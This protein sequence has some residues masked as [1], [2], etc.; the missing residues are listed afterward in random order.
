MAFGKPAVAAAVGGPTDLIEHEGNGLLVPPGDLQQ[1]TAALARLLE[2]EALRAKLGGRASELVK[3]K[4]TFE[5]FAS[6][7]EHILEE[8]W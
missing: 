3:T 8:C 6:E 1:L 7:I 2:D 5:T 4:Y